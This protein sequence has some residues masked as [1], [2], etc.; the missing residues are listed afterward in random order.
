M[1]RIR[2]ISNK[3]NLVGV[4]FLNNFNELH[5]TL[6]LFNYLKNRIY[7]YLSGIENDYFE[8]FCLDEPDSFKV[9]TKEEDDILNNNIVLLFD[10]ITSLEIYGGNNEAPKR[11]WILNLQYFSRLKKLTLTQCGKIQDVE[12]V[13]KVEYVTCHQ[14][15]IPIHFFP[16]LKGASFDGIK[17]ERLNLEKLNL[18]T[19]EDFSF[20]NSDAVKFSDFTSKKEGRLTQRKNNR[21]KFSPNKSR[22]HVRQT[23][24]QD[25]DHKKQIVDWGKLKNFNVSGNRIKEIDCRWCLRSLEQMNISKNSLKTLDDL[26]NLKLKK[27]KVLRA[28]F[29]I[30]TD[31]TL[32]SLTFPELKEVYLSHNHFQSTKFIIAIKNVEILDISCNKLAKI[33]EIR[34]LSSLVHLKQLKIVKNPITQEKLQTQTDYAHLVK[35]YF[36]FQHKQELLVIDNYKFNTRKLA[37]PNLAITKPRSRQAPSGSVAQGM[38][39]G[40]KSK[41]KNKRVWGELKKR[42]Q[43]SK[44]VEHSKNEVEKMKVRRK[45]FEF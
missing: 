8:D 44:S 43:R 1:H 35:E 37:A 15:I 39:T 34:R 20:T 5:L 6:D 10:A 32:L 11:S 3:I 21:K 14:T 30:L 9:T 38:Y 23:F 33:S 17:L 42:Q 41:M 27:L 40:L 18:K 31:S 36:T 19:I 26:N 25:E 2:Q 22:F 12:N 4:S 45:P 28:N 13:N 16:N 7:Q 24:A 29:N